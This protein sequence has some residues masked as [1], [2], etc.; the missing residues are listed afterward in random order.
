MIK[1]AIKKLVEGNDLTFDEA[2]KVMDEIF[3]GELARKSLQADDQLVTET[4]ARI[5]T[6]QGKYQKAVDMY[7]KLSLLK[8]QKSDYFAALI[9]QIKKRIK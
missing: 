4:Y 5:L 9:D 7:M 8:P 3:A 1:E 2:E 6:M